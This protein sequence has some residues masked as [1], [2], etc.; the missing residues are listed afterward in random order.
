[1]LISNEPMNMNRGKGEVEEVNNEE[2]THR[3]RDGTGTDPSRAVTVEIRLLAH[4]CS[5][6]NCI[7]NLRL[8]PSAA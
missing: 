3:R 8:Q 7:V 1:M 4:G 6:V 2:L 5:H